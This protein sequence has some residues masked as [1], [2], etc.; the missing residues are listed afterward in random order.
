[1]KFLQLGANGKTL[2]CC[3]TCKPAGS[4]RVR[5]ADMC[6]SCGMR[7][8]SMAPLDAPGGLAIQCGPCEKHDV[9]LL[10]QTRQAGALRL[11]YCLSRS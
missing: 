11:A 8:A 7:R 2:T 5:P 6:D 10:Q 1:M 4:Q 3:T 9:S